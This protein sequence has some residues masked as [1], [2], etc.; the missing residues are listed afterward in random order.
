MER[1]M[2]NSFAEKML[3]LDEGFRSKP[4]YCT[5]GFATIGYGRKLSDI[6]KTP[7]PNIV[8]NKDDERKFMKE[9]INEIIGRFIAH[10]LK[11]WNNCNIQQQAVLISMAYQLGITGVL[12]FNRMWIAL[13]VAD[14]RKAA[15]EMLDSKWA[16]QTPNRARRLANTMRVGMIDD[17]YLMQGNL[18]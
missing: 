3:M 4:Y 5:E 6:P 18:L 7:L 16:K 14:F 15:D 10:K 12:K 8:T 9:R 13:E 1:Y 17:Y 11:A 2:Q